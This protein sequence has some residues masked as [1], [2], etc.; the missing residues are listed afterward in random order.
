MSQQ[1]GKGVGRALVVGAT[2]QTGSA[3]VQQL[4]EEG[5][6]CS[7]VVAYGNSRRPQYDGPNK[8]LLEPRQAKMEE[9]ASSRSAELAGFDTL[10]IH[11]GTQKRKVGLEAQQQLEYDH[12]LA[13]AAAARA[14]G[15]RAC[16]IVSSQGASAASAVPYL[17]TKGR[18][19]EALKGLGFE[20]LCIYQPGA[21][22]GGDRTTGFF[23]EKV[24]PCVTTVLMF[25]HIEVSRVA[26]AMRR[27]ALQP[28]TAAV[29]VYP[30]A[31]MVALAKQ[32]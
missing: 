4:L 20:R 11:V 10:F 29:E 14:G 27:V 16:R 12:T 30:N 32:P 5:G 3:M 21:L 1:P 31:K 25:S 18:I 2:G 8:Q 19:E 28:A 13:V 26:A 22:H 23:F 7:G 24:L 6:R 9:L 15:C 17:K